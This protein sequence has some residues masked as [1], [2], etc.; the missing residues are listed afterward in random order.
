MT[1]SLS[2]LSDSA[3][4]KTAY[5]TFYGALRDYGDGEGDILYMRQWFMS[6]FDKL[7]LP[8]AYLEINT[9]GLNLS[10]EVYDC[11]YGL[12]PKSNNKAY[13]F[14]EH[15]RGSRVTWLVADELPV[16]RIVRITK[17]GNVCNAGKTKEEK[18]HNKKKAGTD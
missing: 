7:Y 4:G 17:K 9:S 5:M 10:Y 15:K 13:R 18:L 6:I 1:Y 2:F 3:R 16:S 14:L 12:Y 8:K 11:D